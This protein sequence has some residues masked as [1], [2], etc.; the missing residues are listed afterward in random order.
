MTVKKAANPLPPFDRRQGV[1][2]MGEQALQ[3]A[4]SKPGTGFLAVTARMTNSVA[5]TSTTPMARQ[6]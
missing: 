1:R 2:S 6:M 5:I 3:A 4:S